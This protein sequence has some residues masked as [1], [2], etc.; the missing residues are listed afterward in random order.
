MADMVDTGEARESAEQLTDPRRGTIPL[1]DIAE[2]APDYLIA[3]AEDYL[4]SFATAAVLARAFDAVD[5][6]V[7]QGLAAPEIAALHPMLRRM[8]GAAARIASDR[9]GAANAIQLVRGDLAGRPEE[10]C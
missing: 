5:S 8:G 2:G 6:V 7:T 4:L 3:A 10:F 1:A 9:D